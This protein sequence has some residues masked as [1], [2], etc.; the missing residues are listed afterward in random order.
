MLDDLPHVL[1]VEAHRAQLRAHVGSDSDLLRRG[2]RVGIALAGV[3]LVGE[4]VDVLAVGP[5]G[6]GAYSL[7]APASRMC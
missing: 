7:R 1:V 4:G 5:G 6:G 2:Q 3:P